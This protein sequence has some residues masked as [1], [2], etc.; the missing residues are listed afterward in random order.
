MPP[1]LRA[2]IINPNLRAATPPPRHPATPFYLC[3]VGARSSLFFFL[4]VTPQIGY[5][6]LAVFAEGGNIGTLASDFD[7]LGFLALS[8]Y[9]GLYGILDGLARVGISCVRKNKLTLIAADWWLPG[10]RIRS[11]Q[12]MGPC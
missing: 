5:P 4:I 8:S 9:V 1:A 7:A 12:R 2:Q 10:P 6:A 3:S 11:L